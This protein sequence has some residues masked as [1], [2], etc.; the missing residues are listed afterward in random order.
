MYCFAINNEKLVIRLR[1]A[2][3]D[4]KTVV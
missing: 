3:E 4:E 2:L 1:M